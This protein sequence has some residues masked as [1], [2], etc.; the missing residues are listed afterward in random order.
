MRGGVSSPSLP[1]ILCINNDAS[2]TAACPLRRQTSRKCFV[3]GEWLVQSRLRGEWQGSP[4]CHHHYIASW[5]GPRCVP[6]GS[7]T[8]QQHEYARDVVLIACSADRYQ[9]CL[10]RV[11]VSWCYYCCFRLVARLLPPMTYGKPTPDAIFGYDFIRN[12]ALI[13][14]GSRPENNVRN[15]KSEK[16]PVSDR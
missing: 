6:V 13:A 8:Q 10:M 4:S 5:R 9:V 12:E 11:F 2:Q 16:S 15:W 14:G 1:S 7:G 3:F